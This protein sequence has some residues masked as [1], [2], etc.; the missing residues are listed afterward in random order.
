MLGLM[1]HLLHILPRAPRGFLSWPGP[2]VLQV[3]CEAPG[4]QSHI[5]D[6]GL[7]GTCIASLLWTDGNIC[8]PKLVSKCVEISF[9]WEFLKIWSSLWNWMATF[10]RPPSLEFLTQSRFQVLLLTGQL[11]AVPCWG[12]EAGAQRDSPNAHPLLCGCLDFLYNSAVAVTTEENHGDGLDGAFHLQW[13]WTAWVPNSL[14]CVQS[15]GHVQ[16]HTNPSCLAQHPLF[17]KDLKFKGC[18]LKIS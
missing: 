2:L 16:P 15:P 13:D 8:F 10:S 4:A 17:A 6:S 3:H 11:P 9:Q 7:W 1:S 14:G 12:T 5:W 18:V